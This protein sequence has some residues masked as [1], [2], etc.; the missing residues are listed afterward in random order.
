MTRPLRLELLNAPGHI[1]SL[2]I[3]AQHK[4]RKG[5]YT[6]FLFRD[7]DLTGL[8]VE[9]NDQRVKTF[10]LF[11]QD[12]SP[13]IAKPCRGL[14]LGSSPSRL[15]LTLKPIGSPLVIRVYNR[16]MSSITM[17]AGNIISLRRKC[18]YWGVL[19]NV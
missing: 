17:Y 16:S 19:G 9:D 14:I 13:D 3:T 11:N 8:R 2:E 15:S 12:R 7:H 1:I 18:V 10:E 6:F 4:N 5:Q